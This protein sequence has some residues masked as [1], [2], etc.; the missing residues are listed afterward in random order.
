VEYRRH[1]ADAIFFG[2]D[3]GSEVARGQMN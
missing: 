2:A 3:I 1:L